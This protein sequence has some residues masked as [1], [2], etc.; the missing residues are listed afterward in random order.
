MKFRSYKF[1]RFR[2]MVKPT[3]EA[4]Y[5][6]GG[7]VVHPARKSVWIDFEDM[8]DYGE[9]DTDAPEHIWN[10][11]GIQKDKKLKEEVEEKIKKSIEFQTGKIV[12]W[13]RPKKYKIVEVK[14]GEDIKP[15]IITD[16]NA[17]LETREP[18]TKEEIT[19]KISE[20]VKEEG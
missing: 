1:K 13:T 10:G 11:V 3:V 20:I 2:L 16:Q 6:P 12:L 7:G 5:N 17:N 4:I 15:D 19:A 18:L 8:G 9:F 14:E